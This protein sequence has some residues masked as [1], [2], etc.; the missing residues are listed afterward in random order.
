M[1]SSL[2]P[3]SVPTYRRAWNLYTQFSHNIL[4]N[5]VLSL[6]LAPSSLALFIAFL[7]QHNYAASTANTYVSAL[8]YSHRLAG[9]SDPTKVFFI[10]E[11]LKGYGKT[12]SRL[13]TRL[14]ITLHILN[15]I[16]LVSSSISCTTYQSCMFKAMCAMA[17]FA[18]LRI[19]E[20]TVD[21]CQS[22]NVLQLSQ[23]DKLTDTVGAVVSLKVT[24]HNFKHN[25][26]QH[27]IAV[28]LTRHPCV[29]PVQSI[30]DYIDLR[31]PYLA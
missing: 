12:G 23:V 8:G 15:Q 24:F 2:Q 22:L 3:S 26:R 30:L 11:M 17:F 16:M 9:V 6:P 25:Y 13:D 21:N 27:P 7:Y 10:G 1:Q 4:G 28:I 29:C 19:G 14:P 5:A 20:M 31:G 18:F